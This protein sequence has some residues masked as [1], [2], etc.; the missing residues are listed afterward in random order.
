MLRLDSSVMWDANVFRVPDSAPDPELARGISG[1]SDRITTVTV[2]FRI[3]KAYAQ[4]RF[5]ADVSETATRY[6]SFTPL[7]RDAFAYRG[8]WL[9]N[10]TPRVSGTLSVDHTR[11]LIPF[12]DVTSPQPIVRV[13][14]TRN[15]NVD[16]W[17][18]GGWHLLLGATN[19][20]TKN[21][22]VF[23][24]QP[25]YNANTGEVGLKYVAASGNSITATSRSTRGTNNNPGQGIDLVNFIDNEFTVQ[26]SELKATWMISGKSTL[27]GRLTRLDRHNEHLSQ[28]DFSGTTGNFSYIWTVDGRLLVTFSATR[29]I[30]PWTADTQASYRVDD[31]L[32]FAPSLRISERITVRMLASRVVNDFRGPIAPL[33]GPSR[34]DTVRST[35]LAADWSPPIRNLL[36]TGSVQRDRRSSS[37][38]GFDFDDTIAMLSASLTF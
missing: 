15:F 19:A 5:Q 34:R 25:S 3:N 7:N 11:S 1:K 26:E 32:S 4:Q 2:G 6:A 20:E 18:F 10:L 16:G 33:T 21:S 37:A 36:L 38:A 30:S 23:L 29:N 24:A 14:D 8:A 35:Q 9:W 31:T 12:T 22:E 28:R 13:T 27:N 17:I